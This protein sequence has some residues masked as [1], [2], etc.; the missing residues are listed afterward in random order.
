MSSECYYDAMGNLIDCGYLHILPIGIIIFI[1][2]AG[3]IV[4]GIF[5]NIIY[6]LINTWI[7]ITIEKE[8]KKKEKK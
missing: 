1:T 6:I 5:G 4:L 3:L 8:L 7:K 2:I